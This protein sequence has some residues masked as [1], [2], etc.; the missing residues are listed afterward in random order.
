MGERYKVFLFIYFFTAS[1]ILVEFN[2]RENGD[3]ENLGNMNVYRVF[4]D[5]SEKNFGFLFFFMYN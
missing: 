2:C 1:V 4:F 5:N 3:S